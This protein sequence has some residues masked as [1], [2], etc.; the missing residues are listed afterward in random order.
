MIPGM[1]FSLDHF[2]R[3]RADPRLKGPRGGVRFAYDNVPTYLDNSMFAKLV[4]IGLVGTSGTATEFVHQQVVESFLGNKALVFAALFGDDMPQ[5]ERNT[6][7]R[8]QLRGR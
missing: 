1:Y 6:E 3:L 8:N 7:K 2:Q 4:E 5:S